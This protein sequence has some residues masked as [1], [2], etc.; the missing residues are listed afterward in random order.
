MAEII[1]HFAVEPVFFKA[2]VLLIRLRWLIEMK[3]G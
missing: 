2:D 3:A 1:K